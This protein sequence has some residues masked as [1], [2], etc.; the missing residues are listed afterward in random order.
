MYWG[1]SPLRAAGYE[2]TEGDNGRDGL[3]KFE[4][5]D[6]D[7]VV[8]DLLM[9]EMDGQQLLGEIRQR[10]NVPVIIATAD[11]QESSR[12]QCEELGAFSVLNK[13]FKVERLLD[14]VGRA[15]KGEGA[16]L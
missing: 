14:E 9:P 2:V 13:P 6:F 16:R 11:I 12:R 7:L 4:Q 15:L 10:S 3:D 1:A 8:S 5:D